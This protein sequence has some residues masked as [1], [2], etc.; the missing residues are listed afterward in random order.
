ML[1]E[2]RMI[3]REGAR[4]WWLFLLGGVAWLVLAWLVLR[5]NATSIAT[6][7]VLLGVVFLFAGMS[8]AGLA[9]L[10]HGGW[11]VWHVILAIIFFLGA[12]WGFIRPIDTFFA[13]ASVLGLLLFLYG[14]FEIVQG[15]ASRVVNS[16]WWLNL[17]TGILLIL[18]AIW[19]SGS[20]RVYALA[21]RTYL[22]LFWVAFFAIFKGI[23]DIVAAFQIRHI[24]QEASAALG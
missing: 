18:L 1:N 4:Y 3:V 8:E 7:G 15:I 9:A 2:E 24:G 13:L 10:S 14:F 6:V 17:L 5:M 23:M 22:I 11:K 21:Q 19:V 16:M 12:L 20:D